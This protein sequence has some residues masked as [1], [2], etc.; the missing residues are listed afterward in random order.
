M[1][2]RSPLKTD[3]VRIWQNAGRHDIYDD[4]PRAQDRVGDVLDGERRSK[5]LQMAALIVIF[6]F[7]L[8]TAIPSPLAGEGVIAKQ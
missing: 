6:L 4:L 3:L 5:H 1:Y 2:F 7:R 8:R